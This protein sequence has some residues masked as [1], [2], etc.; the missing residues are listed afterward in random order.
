MSYL[1]GK[2]VT[3]EGEFFGDSDGDDFDFGKERIDVG[4]DGNT[5]LEGMK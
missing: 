1:I 3:V 5:I 2:G 4:G